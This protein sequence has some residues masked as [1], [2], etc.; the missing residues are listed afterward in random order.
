MNHWSNEIPAVLIAGGRP[1]EAGV[2]IDLISSAVGKTPGFSVA[3]IGAASGDNLAFFAMMR[4]MLIRAGAGKVTFVRLARKKIDAAAV[5]DTLDRADVLFIS[6]GEV[7]DGMV[8]I[9][10]H[11]LEAYLKG[12][13]AGGK[14]FIC[15]SA[16]AIMMG[17]HWVRWSIPGDDS[18]AELFDCLGIIPD[19]FDTHAEDEDWVELKTVLRLLGNDSRGRGL[20]RG[21]I[22]SADSRGELI[23]LNQTFLTFINDNGQVRLV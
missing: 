2:I 21:C 4:S 15:T 1:I 11:G 16:G 3:Y 20:P 7:E 8:W 18:T 19:V 23:N 12:L 22:I 6:G 9:K 5:Q 10:K 14:L 17:T 13:Y